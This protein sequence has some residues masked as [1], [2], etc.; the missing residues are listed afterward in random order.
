MLF[1]SFSFLVFFLLFFSL[2]PLLKR[3]KQSRWIYLMIASFVFYAW[4]DWRFL[5]LIIF[6]GL[7]DFIAGIAMQA[8]PAHKKW[9]LAFS[10]FGNLGSLAVFKYSAFIASA[11]DSI[12][13]S[14]GFHSTLQ[15]HIPGFFLLLPVGISFYTFQS[16]SY[17]I[18][19]Y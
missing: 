9:W 15:S 14:F 18:D 2:W 17:T 5:F 8:N 4:W 13:S 3:K 16:M 19:I 7:V 1:N 10:L 11:I 6:S 12:L